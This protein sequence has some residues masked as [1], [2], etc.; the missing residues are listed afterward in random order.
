[1][2]A[3]ATKYA[4]G[5]RIGGNVVAF[6]INFGSEIGR[7]DAQIQT[8]HL[9]ISSHNLKKYSPTQQHIQ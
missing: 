4:T 2:T 6:Q 8:R 1:M 7:D 9:P 3:R 5:G